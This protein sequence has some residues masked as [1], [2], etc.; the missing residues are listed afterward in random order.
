MNL[1]LKPDERILAYGI[2]SLILAFVF[3]PVGLFVGLRTRT[4]ARDTAAEYRSAEPDGLNPDF[5]K[6][7]YWLGIAGIVIGGV[8]TGLFCVWLLIVAGAILG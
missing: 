4:L 1:D 8:S 5:V 3:G 2:A 6:I 7:G